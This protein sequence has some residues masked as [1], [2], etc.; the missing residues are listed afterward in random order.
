[1]I[2]TLMKQIG[3]FKRDSLLTPVFMVLEVVM[4]TIIPLLMA[5]IIDDGVEK[6]DIRH[7]YMMGAVMVVM[8]VI[9]LIA[10]VGGGTFGARASAGPTY[11]T[12]ARHIAPIHATNAPFCVTL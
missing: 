3:E 6:G 12:I 5:S 10:G 9:G 1:M 11:I 4:E 2:K 8:A 7:I